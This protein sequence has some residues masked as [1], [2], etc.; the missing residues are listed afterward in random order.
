MEPAA[1]RM[2]GYKASEVIGQSVLIIIPENQRREDRLLMQRIQENRNVERF[3]SERRRKDG[4]VIPVSLTV[5]P[6]LDANDT[7]R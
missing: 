5:S 3:E 6:I 1:E 7:R 2:F 4:T